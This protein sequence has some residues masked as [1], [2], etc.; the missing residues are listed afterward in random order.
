MHVCTPHR[1][2]LFRLLFVCQG[3]RPYFLF[4]IR[5]ALITLITSRNNVNGSSHLGE[6]GRFY[7]I[8][9]SNHE[10]CSNVTDHPSYRDARWPANGGGGV[11]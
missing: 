8:P 5:A 3:C 7:R 11:R 10:G 1:L 2:C 6:R 4:F 9:P